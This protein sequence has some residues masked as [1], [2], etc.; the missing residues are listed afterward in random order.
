MKVKKPS[1]K[2]WLDVI[3]KCPDATYFATPDWVNI[4]ERTTEFK[5]TTRLIILDDGAKAIFP[6][7][8][9]R[10]N[11]KIF[12]QYF[13]VPFYNYGGIFSQRPISKDEVEQIIKKIKRGLPLRKIQ[14]FSHPLSKNCFQKNIVNKGISLKYWIYQWGLIIL[15]IGTKI[16]TK[17]ERPEKKRSELSATKETTIS[18][19]IIKCILI[20]SEDGDRLMI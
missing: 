14:I 13:S 10:K 12:A 15:K 18:K 1:K 9:I 6:L 11:C 17:S 7:M 19:I 2:E 20:L 16:G 8:I 4:V 5:N 3:G